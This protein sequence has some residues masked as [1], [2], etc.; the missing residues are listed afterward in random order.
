MIYFFLAYSRYINSESLR[1]ARRTMTTIWW[2]HN[3]EPSENVSIS[4][5]QRKNIV[6]YDVC[7]LVD[8]VYHIL[9]R[10]VQWQVAAVTHYTQLPTSFCLRCTLSL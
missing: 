4:E 9:Y 8:C 7:K 5:E 6:A 1:T 2:R 10:A 3:N